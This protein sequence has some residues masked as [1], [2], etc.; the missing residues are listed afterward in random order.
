MQGRES[1]RRSTT[2]GQCLTSK[3]DSDNVRDRLTDRERQIAE[4]YANG[5]RYKEIGRKLQL[6]PSTIRTRLSTIYGCATNLWVG[7]GVVASFSQHYLNALYAFRRRGNSGRLVHS[8]SSCHP[9]ICRTPTIYLK[10][11]VSTKAGLSSVLQGKETSPE[12][13][14]AGPR[15]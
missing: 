2:S 11:D 9:Q 7:I 5:M 1:R 13:R 14:R 6:A 4:L 12:G 10:L 3:F 8:V 15:L